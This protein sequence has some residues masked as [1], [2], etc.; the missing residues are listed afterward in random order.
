MY[1]ILFSKMVTGFYNLFEAKYVGMKYTLSQSNIVPKHLP[2]I[3]SCSQ[4]WRQ[5]FIVSFDAESVT[6]ELS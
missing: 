1:T 6:I 3:L 4:K 2:S 5:A